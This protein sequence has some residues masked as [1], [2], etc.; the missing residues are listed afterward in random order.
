MPR[1]CNIEHCRDTLRAVGAT[2]VRQAAWRGSLAFFLIGLWT[3]GDYGITWDE[4]ES[5]HGA[6]VTPKIVSNWFA[7]GRPPHWPW[8]ELR[9]YF[10]PVDLAAGYVLI[11]WKKLLPQWPEYLGFHLFHLILASA[12]LWLVHDAARLVTRDRKLPL[13]AMLALALTPCFVGFS[14]NNPKDLPGLFG[15]LAA[16][17]VLLRSIGPERLMLGPGCVIFGLCLVTREPVAMLPGLVGL[18]ALLFRRKYLR[19]GWARLVILMLGGGICAFAFWPALWDDPISRLGQAY[20]RFKNVHGGDV[21]W[22]GRKY[23][24]AG[25]PWSYTS[26]SFLFQSSLQHLALAALGLTVLWSRASRP[27]RE[28]AGL[29]AI[30]FAIPFAI[31]AP[32]GSKYD[33][34]RHLLFTLPGFSFLA[35]AGVERLRGW[36]PDRRAF[37]AL[38]SL[39][40]L[41][42]LWS[43]ISI[44]PYQ[45]GYLNPL[46]NM[47]YAPTDEMLEV[48]YWGDAYKEGAE[49]LV[50]NAEPEAEIM[51]GMAR[52]CA[53]PFLDRPITD[54]SFTRFAD[55]AMPR[56][57]MYIVRRGFYSRDIMQL[58]QSYVPVHEIKRQ[59]ASLLK[60]YSN[61]LPK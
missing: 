14:Q 25:M 22:M 58:E 6:N 19:H 24:S 12:C 33:W 4:S 53:S 28:L 30:L 23:K 55:T 45:I 56:Y 42:L 48:Q 3:L 2:L 13:Y 8:H 16:L 44:H 35:A 39:L 29:G 10:F 51:V 36:L 57:Y 17:N 41:S 50:R 18:W 15:W 40:A 46:V 52:H 60:I 26:L 43:L 31:E 21:F 34:W 20:M 54:S 37:T 11:A 38:I 49:W 27:A 32:R 47:A 59:A 61:R 1:L 7:G 9:G 5:F